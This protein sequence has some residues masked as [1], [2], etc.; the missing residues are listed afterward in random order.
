[1]LAT[2]LH[3]F[4]NGDGNLDIAVATATSSGTAT[5]ITVFFGNGDGTLQSGL[6]SSI[7]Y[8]GTPRRGMWGWRQRQSTFQDDDLH[9][10]YAR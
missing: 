6:L 8:I 5:G 3:P 1:M 2:W 10:Y 7:S 9:Y 4:H